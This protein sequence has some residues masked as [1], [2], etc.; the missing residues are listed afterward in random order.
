MTFVAVDGVRQPFVPWPYLLERTPDESFA[1][2]LAIRMV[3][4]RAREDRHR[5]NARLPFRPPN[6]RQSFSA[7]SVRPFRLWFFSQV[8]SASGTMTQGVALAWLMLRLTGSGVDLGLL[9]TCSFLPMLVGGPWSGNLIDRSNR[10]RLLI[11]TQSLFITLS[12]LLAV[13]IALGAV[14]VWMLFL[15]AFASGVVGTPDSAARQVYALDLVG[16]DHLTSAISLNEVVLNVSRVVGPA[17]GG[18]LL[19]LEGA[20]A[21]CFVNAASF[22]PPLIVLFVLRRGERPLPVDR[23]PRTDHLLAGL[24]YAL[25]NPTI[26]TSLFFAAA[27]GMLFNLNVPLPLL[28]TRVFH[29]GPGGFGLMMS[30]FGVGGIVGGLVAATGGSQPTRRSVGA[31]AAFTGLSV[32]AT[33]FAPNLSFEYGG[34]LVTGCLSIWFIA[35]ANALVLFEA[36]A[37][38][39]G[40]VM[41]SWT[42]ALPGCEPITSPFVGFV[43]ETVGAREGFAVSGVALIV[44]AAASWRTLFARAKERRCV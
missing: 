40:R 5:T 19:A 14:K 36:D 42:M 1:P 11:V 20:S 28:A 32:L 23:A 6:F 16:T 8:L 31:L 26:R 7:L 44:L 2:S 38:M 33:A 37:S 12:T 13:V 21:C 41:G 3:I 27:S 17:L 30:V 35:R 34:L 39:R 4:R 43:G 24:R 22:V 10:R 18:A 15:F 25:V 9:T 29:L